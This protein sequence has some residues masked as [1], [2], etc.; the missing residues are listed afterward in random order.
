MCSSDLFKAKSDDYTSTIYA[1]ELKFQIAVQDIE[2]NMIRSTI[3]AM[4]GVLGGADVI[5]LE[6][7]DCKIVTEG[8]DLSETTNIHLHHLLKHES[9][10]NQFADPSDGSYYTEHLTK[11]LCEKAWQHF[12]NIEQQG[13]FI[14]TLENGFIQN[15]IEAEAT[16]LGKKFKDKSTTLVGVN[17]FPNNKKYS[18]RKTA[19]TLFID[20]YREKTIKPL[21]L[22][23]Y[24]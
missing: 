13:G 18:K 5:S 4:A 7:F 24:E 10:F 12:Q 16:I 20:K 17:L 2:N 11:D 14:E 19:N 9:F 21:Q 6:N 23:T 1:G 22:F 3:K 15:E 8:S